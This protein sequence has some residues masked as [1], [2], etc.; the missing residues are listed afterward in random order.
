M[1]TLLPLPK[2]GAERLIF[3]P[4]L[5]WPN[6]CMDQ[7]GTWHRGR[8]QPWGLCVRWGPSRPPPKRG[9]MCPSQFSAHFYC[10]RTAGCIIDFLERKIMWAQKHENEPTNGMTN[11]IGGD[12]K[13]SI[14]RYRYQPMYQLISNAQY[15]YRSNRK[16]DIGTGCS[17][18]IVAVFGRSR[19]SHKVWKQ[20]I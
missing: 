9:P 20:H 18:L 4:C 6:G 5:L 16:S 1:G 7:D 17:L 19:S 13:L 8:P 15:R 2:K 14:I 10:G 11:G 3:G 12:T